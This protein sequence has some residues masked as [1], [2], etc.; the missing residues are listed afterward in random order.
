MV[1]ATIMHCGQVYVTSTT[2]HTILFFSPSNLSYCNGCFS[3]K[4]DIKQ[5]G[6]LL[7]SGEVY[8]TITTV[9]YDDRLIDMTTFE[10]IPGIHIRDLINRDS[11][12]K[13]QEIQAIE[14]MILLN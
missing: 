7:Q 6:Y 11:F 9:S 4:T 5:Y 12:M 3:K 13:I 10:P 14:E 1:G 8:A 2:I